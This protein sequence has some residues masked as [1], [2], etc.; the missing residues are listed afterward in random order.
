MIKLSHISA[1]LVAVLVGFSSAI[2][3]VIQAA[4]AAGASAAQINSWLL[5][6]GVG[7]G[8]TSIGL[9]WFYRQPILTAWSTPGAALLVTSLGDLG[10]EGATGVFIFSSILITLTGLSGWFEKAMRYLPHEI[11]AAML[12][13]VLV[14]FGLKVFEAMEQQMLLVGAMFLSYLLGKRLWPRFNIPVVLIL[15]TL[16]AY[17]QGMLLVSQLSLELASLEWVTPEF[18]V[19]SLI[20]IGIPLFVVTMASQNMPGVVVLRNAGYRP[21][22]SPM[23]TW[24]GIVSLLLAPFGCFTLNLAAITAAICAG[25][26]A[27]SDVSTRYKASIIAGVF[28]ILVGL[29]GATVVALFAAFP[30]ELVISIAG[31]ALLS[32]IGNSLNS[33]L[34]DQRLREPALIAF[35]VTAS[36]FSVLGIGSA[37]WG[38]LGG[39]IALYSLRKDIS[40]DISSAGGNPAC[41]SSSS[42]SSSSK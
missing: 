1:G 17:T 5:V 37:F 41:S 11:A 22:V 38:L 8:V 15:A 39:A 14:Q 30:T 7:M 40:S 33:A 29:F 10:I 9:S 16:F 42:S 26:E 27:D 13:G 32:T 3:I 35:L 21:A 31:L 24:T 28:Y 4:E 36:G 12:A 18:H 2:A 23:I 34:S 6:L 25:D 19:A 20:G